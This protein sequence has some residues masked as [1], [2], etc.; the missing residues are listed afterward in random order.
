M[1]AP[2]RATLGRR[3]RILKAAE[4]KAVFGARA[5]ASDGRLVAYAMPNARDVTRV[6]LSV[7]KRCGG[8]VVRARVR[9]LLREA[10]RR[11]RAEFPRGYDVVLVPVAG[12][13]TLADIDQ[14]IRRLV[15]EAIRR[16][17]RKGQAG[18]SIGPAVGRE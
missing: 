3:E 17:E 2:V 5:R 18:P 14:S 7:G 16:A 12:P 9:R 10:F 11:A 6:G 8:A 15:P 13:F 4:F 1:A